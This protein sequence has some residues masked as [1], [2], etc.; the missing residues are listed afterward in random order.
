MKIDASQMEE[1]TLY[2]N[3]R[4]TFVNSQ[5]ES[6]FRVV[7]NGITLNNVIVPEP[8]SNDD[9]EAHS[10]DLS[11]FAGT[12]IRLSLQHLGKHDGDNAYIDNI[13]FQQQDLSVQNTIFTHLMVYPNPT[14]SKLKLVNN[15]ALIDNVEVYSIHGQKLY[16]N[17]FTSNNAE[18]DLANYSTGIYFVKITIGQSEKV[19]KIIKE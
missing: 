19:Y 8:A 3:L 1:L 18:I 9:Y 12:D 10:I 15:F 17:N 7:V 5:N 2:F 16:E 6:L 14:K 13:A 11:A 4:Q